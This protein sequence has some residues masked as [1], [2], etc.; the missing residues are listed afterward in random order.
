MK[1]DMGASA[2]SCYDNP[3]L[4]EMEQKYWALYVMTSVFIVASNI[5]LP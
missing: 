4:V 5:K 2:K 1:F 3:D